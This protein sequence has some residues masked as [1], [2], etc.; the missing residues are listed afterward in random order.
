MLGSL[1]MTP[2]AQATKGKLNKLDSIEI[3]KIYSSK[4]II[5]IPI[6]AQWVMNPT[7]I[8]EDTGSISGLAQ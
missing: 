3:L 2:K 8:H 5:R 7:G 1:D 4:D 6:V